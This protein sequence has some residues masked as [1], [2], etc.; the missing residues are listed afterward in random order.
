MDHRY[1]EE[2]LEKA[3]RVDRGAVREIVAKARRAEGL[4]PSEVARLLQVED[5][6]LLQEIFAAAREI[7][8]K[9]YGKRIVLF[10]PLY[11]SNFCVNNCRYCGYHRENKIPRRRLTMD[12]VREEVRVLESMGH[13][14][15]ALETGEDP[16]N[17]PLDYV[18]EVLETIYSVRFERGSIRRVNVNVAA[19]TPEDYRRLKAA[20]I[21]TY[22]LFQETYHR[23]TYEYMHPAG[24]KAS[25][26]YHLGAM[27]RALSAGIDDVGIGPLFGLYDYKFEVMAVILHARHLDQTFGVGPHTISMP[28]LRPATGMSLEDY[29]HLVSDDDFRKVVAIIRLAVPYTGMILSTREK[30]G[31]RDEAIGLGISQISAGSCTGVGAYRQEHEK[32]AGGAAEEGSPQFTVEDHRSPDE[33]LQNLCAGG[34]LPSYCTA[35][36]RKGRTGDRFMPLA[37][38]G[39]IQ[40]VCQPNAILTFKEYLLDYASPET[41]R[42]G[43]ETIRR[44]LGEI[45]NPLTRQR[46]EERLKQIEEGTRDLYF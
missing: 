11:V 28:R 5:P 42:V 21:G 8:E 24:P 10:A 9:I 37:K 45:K 38:S 36:Y 3:S 4:E 16:K 32:T 2:E 27:D 46:T 20:K 12:E 40:N 33:I 34:Y 44:H 26:E 25:Y 30:P 39:Q 18:L 29:P 23:P 6:D 13:K 17:C 43:E 19:T 1:V 41:R 31:F 35:C 7:K 22:I 15:L 14:R